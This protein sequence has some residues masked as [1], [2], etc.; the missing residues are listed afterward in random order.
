MVHLVWQP[1]CSWIRIRF[2]VNTIVSP[3][4]FCKWAAVPVIS[5]VPSGVPHTT[6]PLVATEVRRH[7]ATP[8]AASGSVL[9]FRRQ[10]S[11][12]AC[13]RGATAPDQ[14]MRWPSLHHPSEQR[15]C[16]GRHDEGRRGALL[17]VLEG[18]DEGRCNQQRPQ[19][20]ASP[21]AGLASQH[22]D[23]PIRL[24]RQ[25]RAGQ[26]RSRASGS[27]SGTRSATI[28]RMMLR[29]CSTFWRSMHAISTPALEEV[30]AEVVP[31]DLSTI[32]DADAHLEGDQESS[33]AWDTGQGADAGQPDQ[34]LANSDGEDSTVGPS[35]AV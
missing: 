14:L 27:R 17:C 16:S 23:V 8:R 5:H 15:C 11:C 28:L 20:A 30:Q 18:A 19:R 2:S 3:H 7:A 34:G 33:H 12:C 32:G 1:T 24:L 21:V 9:I 31:Q 4:R 13:S 25:Q 10:P 22:R 35:R 29:V 6:K 26:R